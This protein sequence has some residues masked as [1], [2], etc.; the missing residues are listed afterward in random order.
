MAGKALLPDPDRIEIAD[1][2]ALFEQAILAMF[3]GRC[4]GLVGFPDLLFPCDLAK[5]PD[6]GFAAKNPNFHIRLGSVQACDNL[7]DILLVPPLAHGGIEA[8]KDQL[9]GL[10]GL[11]PGQIIH[12][13]VPDDA[14]KQKYAEQ[15]EN[16][17]C[18]AHERNQ[19]H[20]ADGAV[21]V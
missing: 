21:L 19:L 9:R 14:G 11:L 10:P 1:I 13:L 2:L 20:Q 17:K 4:D 5:L 3:K 12:R 8:L 16:Q 6:H 18:K 15:G 7:P